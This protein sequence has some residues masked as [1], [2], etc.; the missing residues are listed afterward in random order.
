LHQIGQ[1]L[2]AGS[3]SLV[4]EATLGIFRAAAAPL[5]GAVARL[6]SRAAGRVTLDDEQFGPLRRR[7]QCSRR[8]AGQASLRVALLRWVSFSALRRG[9]SSARS[10]TQSTAGWP[11]GIAGEPVIDIVKSQLQ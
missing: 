7:I 6:L 11:D 9:R 4:A 10:T 1:L 5:A 2:V 8:L 3:L